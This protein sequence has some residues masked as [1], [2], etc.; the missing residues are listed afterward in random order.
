MHISNSFANYI[1][2]FKTLNGALKEKDRF[3][4][5][6][7]SFECTFGYVFISAK[8]RFADRE[9]KALGLIRSS[10]TAPGA[11]VALSQKSL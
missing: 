11:L 10:F 9:F 8:N 2:L 5:R 1:K 7:P 6:A 3:A 4:R